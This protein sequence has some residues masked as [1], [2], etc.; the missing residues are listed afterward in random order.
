MFFW[1]FLRSFCPASPISLICPFLYKRLGWKTLLEQL[2]HSND[3]GP[4][5]VLSLMTFIMIRA[6]SPSLSAFLSDFT[7]KHF[8]LRNH[9]FL[10]H[11]FQ[12]MLFLMVLSVQSYPEVAFS[13]LKMCHTAVFC[14]IGL[15]APT[16][17]F[18]IFWNSFQIILVRI[19]H[20]LVLVTSSC[21]VLPRL[22]SYALT[23]LLHIH[24]SS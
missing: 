12:R 11:Q 23:C 2:N 20:R 22:V 13:C 24:L 15:A 4:P 3:R 18:S 9:W 17:S 19:L 6:S 21:Q 5:L 16:V 8:P 7:L 10:S 14:D 1:S